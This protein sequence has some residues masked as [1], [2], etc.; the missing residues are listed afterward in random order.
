MRKRLVG[1]C[2]P[3]YSNPL[4]MAHCVTLPSVD[5]DTSTSA[6]SSSVV[7]LLALA[8]S[9][10]TQRTCQT[11]LACLPPAVLQWQTDDRQT[12]RATCSSRR[13]CRLPR[14]NQCQYYMLRYDTTRQKIWA[15]KNCQLNLALELKRTE[16]VP[17]GNKRGE[18]ETRAL[19]CKK[20]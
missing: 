2:I 18:S 1:C 9:F 10:S 5:T 3:L 8:W 6:C 20:N 19:S 12:D 15:D 13:A 14:C 4:R 7:A 16:N 11:P 17:Y